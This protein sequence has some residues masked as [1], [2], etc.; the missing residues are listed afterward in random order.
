MV[1]FLSEFSNVTD[2]SVSSEKALKRY[3]D[4]VIV[5]DVNFAVCSEVWNDCLLL[6]HIVREDP[7][8]FIESMILGFIIEIAT[9]CIAKPV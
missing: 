6:P 5:E 4:E 8:P 1:S 2:G 9:E 7:Q 3:I